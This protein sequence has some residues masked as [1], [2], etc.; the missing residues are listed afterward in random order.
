MG[1]SSTL[2][3][4]VNDDETFCALLPVRLSE[5]GFKRSAKIEALNLGVWG[6]SSFQ[7]LI[8]YETFIKKNGLKPDIALIAYGANDQLPLERLGKRFPDSFIY[9]L[10]GEGEL[11]F[12][13]GAFEYFGVIKVFHLSLNAARSL[14]SVKRRTP[15]GF[16]E[17]VT[18][19]E[20]R[21]NILGIIRLAREDSAMPILV[22]FIGEETEYKRALFELGNAEGVPVVDVFNVFGLEI[23]KVRKEGEYSG[24]RE[25]IEKYLKRDEKYYQYLDTKYSPLLTTD[26]YHPGKIGHKIVAEEIAKVVINSHK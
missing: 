6:Y 21:A 4:D 2:G 23:E 26:G 9:R 22:S 24:E 25:E 18:L 11:I 3:I 10:P 13:F 12:S 15:G 14:Y 1:D 16:S 5:L 19:D 7:G 20:F 8:T 17:R